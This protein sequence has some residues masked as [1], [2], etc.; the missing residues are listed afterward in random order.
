MTEYL[1]LYRQYDCFQWRKVDFIRSSIARGGT[2]K[3]DKDQDVKENEV[4]ILT[5]VKTIRQIR[6]IWQ[7]KMLLSLN[8]DTAE[9]L[10]SHT[11]Q[12]GKSTRVR[13]P[14]LHLAKEGNFITTILYIYTSSVFC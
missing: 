13:S 4:H 7:V 14:S 2:Q 10:L 12:I 3:E 9:I 5:N 8:H 6:F 11:C 1:P